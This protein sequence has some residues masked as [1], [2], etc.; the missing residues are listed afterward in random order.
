V[1][2]GWEGR[3]AQEEIGRGTCGSGGQAAEDLANVVM[4]KESREQ[5]GALALLKCDSTVIK[6]HRMA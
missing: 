3:S 2:S 5:A 1:R 4:R 6:M